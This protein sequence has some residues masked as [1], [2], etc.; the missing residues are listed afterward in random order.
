MDGIEWEATA[1][2]SGG[3]TFVTATVRNTL[4]TAQ[5]VRLRS[6]LDGPVWPPSRATATATDWDGP[7]WA[8]TVEPGGQRG[9]GFASPAPPV[10]SP[11]TIVGA[12]RATD[13]ERGAAG[14]TL[15]ALDD[16][17]PPASVLPGEP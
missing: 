2:R 3:V 14:K 1:R 8:G 13:D 7:V 5:R 12:R 4:R 15:A 16:W 17:A 6:T 10:E 11:L 9:L